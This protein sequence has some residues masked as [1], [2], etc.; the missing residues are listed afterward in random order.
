MLADR[1]LYRMKKELRNAKTLKPH[2]TEEETSGSQLTSMDSQNACKKD[3]KF[4]RRFKLPP[5][6]ILVEE[7]ICKL[8]LADPTVSSDIPGTF[9]FLVIFLG[10]LSIGTYHICFYGRLFGLREKSVIPITEITKI[11]KNQSNEL[12]ISSLHVQV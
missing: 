1:F 7:F 3:K 5:N 4:I 10:V 9:H 6:E 2:E 8:K 11:R 12:E